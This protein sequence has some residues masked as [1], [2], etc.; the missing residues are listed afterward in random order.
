MRMNEIQL[1]ALSEKALHDNGIRGFLFKR[2]S[3]NSKWQLRYFNEHSQKP[4]GVI[5]LE[6]SYCDRMVTSSSKTI[7][8]NVTA[9]GTST[10][11]Q[12]M[13]AKKNSKN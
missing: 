6:G 4:S 9:T 2:T 1:L 7:T 10:N 12:V 8:A 3:E 5:F 13:F 11:L